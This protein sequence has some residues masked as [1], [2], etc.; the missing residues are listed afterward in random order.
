MAKKKLQ[1]HDRPR[2]SPAVSSD[3]AELEWAKPSPPRH[4]GEEEL[5][6]LSAS[7]AEAVRISGVWISPGEQAWVRSAE[8]K[9]L[10]KAGQAEAVA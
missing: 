2:V 9:K 3:A 6:Q 10:I 1:E 7:E 5:V 4:A 8:A